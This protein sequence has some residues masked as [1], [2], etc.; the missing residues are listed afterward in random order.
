MSP[1]L[2]VQ[3]RS[4]GAQVVAR[5]LAGDR[6]HGVRPQLAALRRFRDRG[7]DLPLHPDLVGTDRHLDLERRHAGVLADGPLA[8]G[9]LI[10]VLRD[11]RQRLPGTRG[12]RLGLQRQ[13]HGLAHVGRQIGRGARDQLDH[14]VEERR[15]HTGQYN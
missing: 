5:V 15:K 7:L 6:I 1:L 8:A 3:D 2:E 11:D 10:D 9:G 4:A 13:A 14:A 12:G